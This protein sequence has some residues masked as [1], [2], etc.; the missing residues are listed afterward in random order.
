MT[1][2]AVIC[3]T[4]ILLYLGRTG[5]TGLLPAQFSPIYVPEAVLLELDMGR[6]TR[7]DT[8][9]PRQLAWAHIVHVPQVAIDRL[10]PNRLVRGER[11]V[12]AYAQAHAIDIVGLDDLQ[13]V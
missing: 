3:D 8:I 5:Q 7:R 2:R 11:S 13:A 10:P 1:E 12:L 9:D 6:V 4:T